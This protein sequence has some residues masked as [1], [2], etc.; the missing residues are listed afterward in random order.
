MARLDEKF[1]SG[2]ATEALRYEETGQE[3]AIENSSPS[4]GSDIEKTAPSQSANAE[5]KI[6]WT[7][8][9]LIAT[10]CLAGLYVGKLPQLAP[11]FNVN[12]QLP[13][14]QLPLYFVGGSLR[15]I[16]K[17][18]G[19]AEVAAWMPVSYGLVFA[20]VAPFCGYLQ[21]LFGRRN[22]TLIGGL[23]LIIG[24]IVIGTARS[25]TSGVVGMCFSGAGATIVSWR[26]C[27]SLNSVLTINRAN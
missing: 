11:V 1:G 9:T 24:I 25:F 7:P 13:G 8:I 23:T 15:F 6:V 16:S 17:E 5:G 3:K 27:G 10:I 19:G 4:G 22:I 18:L 21:D 20:A 2:A 14:S 12:S 26:C